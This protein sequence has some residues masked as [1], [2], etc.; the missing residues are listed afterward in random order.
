MT[1][2]E[3]DTC[4]EYDGPPTLPSSSTDGDTLN[5][6][7]EV[8]KT[9]SI[10]EAKPSIDAPPKKVA[11]GRLPA[12]TFYHLCLTRRA[13]ETKIGSNISRSAVLALCVDAFMSSLAHAR[14]EGDE[15]FRMR[16]AHRAREYDRS[17][18]LSPK[19]PKKPKARIG[20]GA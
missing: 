18:R 13:L 10:A 2:I 1:S 20:G 5:R 8:L 6:L 9:R 15:G 11:Y 3:D 14:R 19:S 16:A 17:P 12:S 4:P 7:A